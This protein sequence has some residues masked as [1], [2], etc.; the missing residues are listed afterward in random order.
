MTLVKE[1]GGLS[2]VIVAESGHM[3]PMD[4]PVSAFDLMQRFVS[5]KSLRDQISLVKVIPTNASSYES[6]ECSSSIVMHQDMPTLSPVVGDL[7]SQDLESQVY[8]LPTSSWLWILM[9]SMVFTAVVSVKLAHSSPRYRMYQE[10]RLDEGD[11]TMTTAVSEADDD[12]DDDDN[13]V[14]I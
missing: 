1:G 2:F 7:E 14:V 5:H 11:D 10:A 4:A 3:V 13:T 8:L 12:D 9:F 6:Q